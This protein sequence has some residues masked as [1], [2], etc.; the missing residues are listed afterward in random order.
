MAKRKTNDEETPGF[1]DSLA[2]LQQIVQ[3]LEDGS[4]GL[5]ESLQQFERGI[6]LLRSCYALLE[7]AEQKIEILTGFDAEGKPLT[8]AFD[9][10]STL[11]TSEGASRRRRG[12]AAPAK[13]DDTDDSSGGAG[14]LF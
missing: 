14:A 7:S 11:S 9:A 8:E 4:Q 6:G 1:E 3:S 10:S 12:T 5:E 2:E 13:A